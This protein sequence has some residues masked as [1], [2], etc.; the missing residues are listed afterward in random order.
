M[1]F[2]G[3]VGSFLVLVIGVISGCFSPGDAAVLFRESQRIGYFNFEDF[4]IAR[5]TLAL[6]SLQVREWQIGRHS[7]ERV[8]SGTPRF[9][10]QS[11]NE[12]LQDLDTTT[13]TLYSSAHLPSDFLSIALFHLAGCCYWCF[14]SLGKMS[15]SRER[16]R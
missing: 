16:Y 5:I 14:G 4:V 9:F 11:R 3:V 15:E 13:R 10:A 7:G 8:F 6:L 2:R 1:C 12:I